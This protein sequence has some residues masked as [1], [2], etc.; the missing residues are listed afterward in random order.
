VCINK[1]TLSIFQKI[2]Y[3][4]IQFERHTHRKRTT[5]IDI[6]TECYMYT[7]I[8]K[9]KDKMYNVFLFC[10]EKIFLGLQLFFN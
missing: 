10:C 9:K 5:D 2:N 8:H 1:N 3:K 4:I 7:C 6:A